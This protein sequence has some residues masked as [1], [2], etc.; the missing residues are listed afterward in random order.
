MGIN[1]N[2]SDNPQEK[3]YEGEEIVVTT[4]NTD[5]RDSFHDDDDKGDDP[6]IPWREVEQNIWW[7]VDDLMIVHIVNGKT[8]IAVL[9]KKNGISVTAWTTKIIERNL[10]LKNASKRTKTKRKYFGL[11]I[12]VK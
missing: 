1:S 8:M 6:P 3:C 11:K 12:R 4:V 7:R 5:S 2:G 10:K 9:T